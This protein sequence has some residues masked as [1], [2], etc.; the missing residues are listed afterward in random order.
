M[1]DSL[2][3]EKFHVL[4]PARRKLMIILIAFTILVVIPLAGYFYYDFAVTRPSRMDKEVYFEI[5][6]G[7]AVSEIAAELFQ[8][9]VIN[10]EFLFTTYIIANGYDKNIQAGQYNI[11]PGLS[12]VDLANLFQHGIADRRITF[13]EGW[14]VEEFAREA[15]R[16]YQ[17]IDYADFVKMARPL[18]GF[19]FPD[20]Y[21]FREDVEEAD[22][23]ER[24]KSTFDG[25][26]SDIL[27]QQKL[28]EVGLTKE[29][30]VIFASIIERE[31]SIPEDR[32][33]VAGILLKRW[34]ED[35]K[36]DADATVQYAV[37]LSKL[38]GPSVVAE[39]IT[40][41]Q[42][43]DNYS[44][45]D[46]NITQEDLDT[47]SPYN[48]RKIVG[49]PPTP[50]ASPGIGAI[51]AV[52]NN[53]PSA[54]YYYLSDSQGVTHFARTIEEHNANVAKYLSF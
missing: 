28:S 3:P 12:I 40:E 25:K 30:V 8:K 13:L 47:D 11:K 44:W 50:I 9:C 26:T 5:K 42:M 45:W 32:A 33:I 34:R 52:L 54:Y 35:M 51:E 20:T 24:L 23:I 21:Y 15:A 14:R 49:L 16:N 1:P 53:T 18:E 31:I 29:Q 39:C 22:I 2:D 10:S 17:N 48:T 41:P 19:L 27:T 37:G 46:K 43:L 36:I 7:E 38:C 6:K 4:T